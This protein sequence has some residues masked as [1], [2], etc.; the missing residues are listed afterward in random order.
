MALYRLPELPPTFGSSSAS[1]SLLAAMRVVTT[2]H[3]EEVAKLTAKAFHSALNESLTVAE[4]GRLSFPQRI[5]W[6]V[7]V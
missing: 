4:V 2:N 6:M 1:H 5:D 7:A 3:G